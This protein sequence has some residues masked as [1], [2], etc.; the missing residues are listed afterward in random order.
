MNDLLVAVIF[1]LLVA[2][3][4]IMAAMPLKDEEDQPK[5]LADSVHLPFPTASRGR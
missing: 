2:S 5:G 4:A 3:P 1:L